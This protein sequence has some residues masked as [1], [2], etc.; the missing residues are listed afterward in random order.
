M[1]EVIEHRVLCAARFLDHAT[2]RVI[3]RPLQLSADGTRFI[4]NRSN[5]YVIMSA[6]ALGSVPIRS[7][8]RDPL[9]RYLPRT[10]TLP[11]PRDPDPT[12][13]GQPGSLFRPVDV[14][15][16]C[17]STASGSPNWSI[18]R[19][20]VSWNN[21]SVNTEGPACG[22]L[23]RVVSNSDGELLAS[24]VS[25]ERG[26]ALVVIPGVPIT[27]FSEG[28]DSDGDN[29]GTDNDSEGSSTG[30][31]MA[32]EIAAR[33]EVIFDPNASWPVDPDQLETDRES[34]LRKTQNVVLR[35]GRMDKVTITLE[36][37]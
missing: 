3:T 17:A 6:P 29:E 23:L 1:S 36:I 37:T 12:H 30:P 28:G 19:A 25:D 11:L 26:E 7:T 20:S 13:S 2:G 35:T 31:V 15:M 34:L 9:G 16:Y 21:L 32:F 27:T 10:F 8:I 14:N 33:L 18:I 4:R 5:M 24:S 22:A